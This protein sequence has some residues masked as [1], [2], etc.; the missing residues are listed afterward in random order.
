MSGFFFHRGA[1]AT[2]CIEGGHINVVQD[3]QGRQHVLPAALR[4]LKF[5][6]L[7]G[8]M[9]VSRGTRSTAS[10]FVQGEVTTRTTTAEDGTVMSQS[11]SG[12]F[13]VAVPRGEYRGYLSM[14]EALKQVNTLAGV[15]PWSEADL[16][17]RIESHPAYGKSLTYVA[18]PVEADEAEADEPAP[19]PE[20][21]PEPVVEDV[22]AEFIADLVEKGA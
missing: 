4:K 3:A 8:A 13:Q 14:A 5:R 16:L 1:A 17:W 18:G 7:G 9:Q 21:D 22:S 6:P 11:Q 2:V 20:P 19:D 10:G 12:G 15:E